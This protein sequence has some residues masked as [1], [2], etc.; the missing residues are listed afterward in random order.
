MKPTNRRTHGKTAFDLIE[1]ATHLLRT[2]P[3]ATLAVYF[4]GT[5]PFVLG[6]LFFWADMSRSPLAPQ[7]LAAG[8][9][10]MA[11][12]FFWM[13]FCQ[14]VF[15]RRIRAQ[16]ARETYLP[17]GFRRCARIFF[18][19][20]IVQ[21]SGLFLLPLA[22]A[23]A[24]PFPWVYAYYQNFAALDD[25]GD[26]GTGRIDEKILAGRPK[27]WPRQN[28]VVLAIMFAFAFCVFLNWA[29]V[30]LMLPHLGK[31]LLGIESDVHPKPVGH[32]E[33]ALFLPRCSG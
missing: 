19:Q 9:L 26:A 22:C 4:L 28:H 33:H 18:M 8:S 23:A 32:V 7:H 24:L 13:K 31:T 2:A 29:T 25:G 21:P 30:C 1:E 20:A 5:V 12:L 10:G 17:P 14:A 6:V 16:A 27:L 11:A 15:A 3:A